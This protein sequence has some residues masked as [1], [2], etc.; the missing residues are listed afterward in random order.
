MKII[1]LILV[2]LS[3]T[4]SSLYAQNVDRLFRFPA[5]YNDTIVFTYA[6]DLYSVSKAG[7][8]ARKLTSAQG[9]EMFAHFSPDGKTIAFTGQ[10][11]GNTEVY[12]IPSQGGVPKRLTYTATLHRDDISDR[13]GP[14]NMVVAWTPDGSEIVYRSRKQSFNDF[15]GSLFK[16]NRAGGMS[17]PLPLPSGGFCSYSSDGNKLAYNR[18]MREFRTWKYYQGGMADDIWIYDF[19][20]KTTENISNNIAQDIFP[21]WYGDRIFFLSDR[22]RIMNLFSY[23]ITTKEV[24][25]LTQFKK[26]DIKFPSIHGKQIVF[27]NE[28]FIYVYEIDIQT[29]TKI[30]I[31][32]NNDL[33]DSRNTLVNGKDY[34]NSI[35]ISPQ[36]KRIAISAR[37]DLFNIPV[38][39][40]ISYNLTQSSGAF[41]RNAKW[42]PDGKY[43]AY[44]S[45]KG[46]E[47]DLY[48]QATDGSNIEKKLSSVEDS[49]I[50][51]IEWAPNS[52]YILWSDKKMDLKYVNI[53]TKAIT[54]VAHSLKWEIT[55]YSWSPD[56]RWIAY[57]DQDGKG[58]NQIYVYDIESN[59]SKTVTDE[60]YES[61]SPVFS[62]DGHYLFFVS[63]RTFNPIYSE[64]EWNHAYRNMSKIYLIPLQQKE[65]SPFAPSDDLEE[66]ETEKTKTETEEAVQVVIDFENIYKRVVEL[67][68]EA[69]N[70]WN[71]RSI[72]NSLY[73]QSYVFGKAKSAFKMYDLKEEKETLLGENINYDYAP[74]AK[75]MLVSHGNQMQ[76]I[77]LPKASIKIDKPIDLG[78]LQIWVNKHQEWAQIY[79]ESW[80]QMR[81]FFYDPNMHGVDWNEMYKKYEVLVPYVN[82]RNDLNYIIGELIGELNVG[83]A[84]TGGGDRPEP[85]RYQTGLLGAQI[86]K[87]ASGYFKI[88]KILKGENFNEQLRSPLLEPGLNVI[89]GNFIVAVDGKS[90]KDYPDF[91][92][93][94]F[95]KGNTKVALKI[96][97]IASEEGAK[98]IIVET[99]NDE[100]GL[101]YYNWVQNNIEKVSKATNGE[102]GYI[103]IPDMGVEGLNEFVKYWYPQLSKKALIIDDRGNGGGNVSPMLI[104]RL[105][106]EI[107]RANI[108][109][110]V[111]I[112]SQTPTKM[113]RGP[114]VLLV[115]GYSASDGDLFPYAFRKHGLGQIIG[116][117]TW[118]GVV[119]IRGSL[120][121]IDGG[122]LSKPEF[123]SYAADGSEWIIEGRG[124]EPDIVIDNDPAKE[125][126]GIDEQLNKAIEEIMKS[127]KDYQELPT[128]PPYPIKSK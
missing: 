47:Y 74:K 71:I 111:S 80:R 35:S 95:N 119:G 64:T 7:G 121:F 38:K 56:S 102:V 6:G 120:P 72:G 118:G 11:D 94:M 34:I 18:V 4:L 59:K 41:D 62:E 39:E 73:Y 16:V 82:N 126:L 84:Y 53:Q 26:Y 28:G 17:S 117:R 104:E 57:S 23:N 19:G 15:A 29:L 48:I 113:M 81:D 2:A 98:T 46:G 115:N 110:N 67:P 52:Q 114:L 105:N 109:R 107:T 65:K 31:H 55:D 60:W 122:T 3:C 63:K 10:F 76:V 86:S 92:E 100:S 8:Q 50:F 79:K 83:H 108:A 43:I 27:E 14:N 124:V 85:T 70:Y 93:L 89:E 45:D 30:N 90:C 37:G 32:I 106:R 116:M 1:T 101:Y 123:A 25:K 75:K 127:L 44:L 49:Y 128:P 78:G 5:I 68:I 112:P 77:D 54:K 42:S 13:M 22:D 69:G 20:K 87:D 40:G 24:Q 12:S 9:Y 66:T 88:D 21:M 33:P 91:Y 99:I 97:S 61:S 96:N 125:Y 58:M 103:H 51:D 36:A